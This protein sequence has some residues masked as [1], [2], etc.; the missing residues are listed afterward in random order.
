MGRKRHIDPAI[1][2]NPFRMVVHFFSQKGHPA[3]PAPG[4][5][6]GLELKSLRNGV[7]SLCL[8]P[9]LEFAEDPD[10]LWTAPPAE[11]ERVSQT[12]CGT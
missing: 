9:A 1:N 11:E 2:I 3:H 8:G 7:P 10:P 4:L 5:V 6:E 12:F